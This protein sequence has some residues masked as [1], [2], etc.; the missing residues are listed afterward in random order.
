MKGQGALPVLPKFEEMPFTMF[1]NRF[2]EVGWMLH[3]LIPLLQVA[4]APLSDGWRDKWQVL[5][6]SFAQTV[7]SLTQQLGKAIGAAVV[8][9]VKVKFPF[10]AKHVFP[11]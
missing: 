6:E 11:L 4:E 8:E 9:L 7:E 5:D 10:T 3:R 1:M 2:S